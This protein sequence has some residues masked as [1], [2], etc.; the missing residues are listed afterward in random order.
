MRVANRRW[1]FITLGVG[2]LPLGFLHLLAW[3]FMVFAYHANS[4]A[5]VA[6][7]YL[8]IYGLVGTAATWIFLT[9][10][11]LDWAAGILLLTS[12]TRG[13]ALVLLTAILNVP[14]IPLGSIVGATAALMLLFIPNRRQ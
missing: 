1:P 5:E 2:F 6:K 12:R 4:I 10:I 3:L 8:P 14:I 9:T 7:V 11:I 13:R